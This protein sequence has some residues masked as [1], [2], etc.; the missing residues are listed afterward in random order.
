MSSGVRR[1]EGAL[2]RGDVSL[3][4]RYRPYPAYKDSGVEWLGRIPSHWQIRAL[5]RGFAVR[6]G[7]ML[8]NQPGSSR[9]TLE[10]YLRA[11]NLTWSGVDVTDIR[12]MWFSPE[13][14][15]SYELKPGDLLVS[16]GGDVGR[17]SRWRGEISAC[18]IQNAINRVRTRGEALTDFLFY[19]IYALKHLGYIDMFC[20]KATISHFTAEKVE[21]LPVLFPEIQEQ[22]AI[23]K[24]LDR[25]TAKIDALVAKKE[26]LIELLQEK[27]TALITRAVT[28]GLDPNVPM[29]ASGVEWLGEN[30]AHWNLVPIKRIPARIQTGST[31]PTADEDYYQ[32][33]TVPWYSPTSFGIQ[34]VLSQPTKLIHESA[35]RDGVARLFD[36]GST[37]VVTIGAT[38]GK[39]GYIE[40]PA[41]SNQQI[42][43][44]TPNPHRGQGKFVAYELKSLEPVLQGIAPNTTLP[45]I[46]QQKIG[47]LPAI[48]PPLEE[49]DAIIRFI[50]GEL[51]KIDALVSKI[52]EGI[53][54]LREYRTALISAA[55]TGKI[56][57]HEEA[58]R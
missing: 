8:Q 10:F 6:L 46:D 29:R 11:A 26:R 49:Q 43:A 45:I 16:E 30:P 42:T 32:D 12:S 3:H 22:T 7:K 13:E 38:V 44:I 35:V 5:K 2:E 1:H 9:D 53:E 40:T 47:Y 50:E 24:F 27:R 55:V 17:A 28:R 52:R 41:S 58:G 57:V 54:P 39:V 51:A 33:G 37:L 25:E 21:A 20:S 4:S 23:A 19:W 18:Y 48:L 36:G 34:M 31:P 14:K 56:D 15:R